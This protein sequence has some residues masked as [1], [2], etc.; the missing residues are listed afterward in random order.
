MSPIR[1][2]FY[3]LTNPSEPDYWTIVCRLIHKA[4]TQGHR[5]LV[6]CA[7]LA[8][9]RHLDAL[10]WSYQD[11]AF[12]PHAC[13]DDPLASQVA[14]VITTP[15]TCVQTTT[16]LVMNLTPSLIEC[17]PPISRIIEVILPLESNKAIAREH[18]RHYRD[19][20]FDLHTHTMS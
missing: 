17:A 16:S 9:C 1:V 15:D 19:Q 18:Y 12:I 13:L 3:L 20:G 11:D 8:Q 10:L 14:V 6:Y 5:I 2:D 7:Q 4:Y